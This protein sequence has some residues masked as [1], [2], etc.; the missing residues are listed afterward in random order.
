MVK[1]NNASSHFYGNDV[2]RRRSQLS[3]IIQIAEHFHGLP[4][5]STS[6]RGEPV[7]TRDRII[8]A[9]SSGLMSCVVRTAMAK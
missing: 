9:A 1:Q 6:F 4:M 3:L 5:K 2:D 7:R 8:D